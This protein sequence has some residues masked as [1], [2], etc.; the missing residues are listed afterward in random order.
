VFSTGSI[1]LCRVSL[2]AVQGHRHSIFEGSHQPSI[3]L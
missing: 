2:T 1:R 3:E